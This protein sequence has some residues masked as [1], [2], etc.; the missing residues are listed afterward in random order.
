M[1]KDLISGVFSDKDTK[2]LDNKLHYFYLT[3]KNN[4]RFE[5]M[6]NIIQDTFVYFLQKDYA[7]TPANFLWKFKLLLLDFLKR[8]KI[9]DFE[10][11][12]EFDL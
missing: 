4:V 8:K 6:Q 3:N 12:D 1:F 7:L 2:V 10:R 9:V 11:L 5:D